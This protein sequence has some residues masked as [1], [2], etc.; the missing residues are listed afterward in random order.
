[1]SAANNG[2]L[3][4]VPL[5]HKW[6][7][8][9]TSFDGE[10]K[11]ETKARILAAGARDPRGLF[12]G[13]TKRRTVYMAMSLGTTDGPFY[14]AFTGVRRRLVEHVNG[15]GMLESPHTDNKEAFAVHVEVE[16]TPHGLYMQ[17]LA[18][19]TFVLA[20]PG[21]PPFL[22]P[23]SST[24]R[25]GLA[26]HGWLVGWFFLGCRSSLLGDSRLRK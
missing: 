5:G 7:F 18:Q 10:S 26:R 8:Y 25:C 22:L 20:P 1:M 21:K 12:S 4:S 3:L 24:E 15:T 16:G 2:K 13:N 11:A 9:S 19:S 17:H 23:S 6:Q 14:Q